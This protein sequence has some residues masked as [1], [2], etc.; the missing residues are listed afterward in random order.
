MSLLWTKERRKIIK[1]EI[2]LY[3]TLGDLLWCLNNACSVLI[4]FSKLFILHTESFSRESLVFDRSWARGKKREKLVPDEDDA[5]RNSPRHNSNQFIQFTL[6][7]PGCN[8]SRVNV[9]D[10]IFAPRGTLGE[11]NTYT[12]RRLGILFRDCNY[13]WSKRE[14]AP[15]APSLE[16]RSEGKII[17]YNY[18]FETFLKLLSP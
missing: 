5:L 7:V 17:N 14:N 15:S 18:L 4:F 9:L 10:K 2:L 12:K 16:R 6:N 8:Q 11:S 13:H 3:T 1:N